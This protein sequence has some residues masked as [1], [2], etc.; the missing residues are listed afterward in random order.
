MLFE[1]LDGSADSILGP[2]LCPQL[3]RM[4]A[5]GSIVKHSLETF[6]QIFDTEPIAGDRPWPHAESMNASSPIGLV[7]HERHD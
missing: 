4:H 3:C 7:G 1:D 2:D 5:H 6:G